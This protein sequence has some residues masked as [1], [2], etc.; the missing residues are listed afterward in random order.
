M[1]SVQRRCADIGAGDQWLYRQIA[2]KEQRL[3]ERVN[4]G[5]IGE[6]YGGGTQSRKEVVL[7]I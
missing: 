4:F 6:G 3:A 5:H 7:L 1:G 2:T